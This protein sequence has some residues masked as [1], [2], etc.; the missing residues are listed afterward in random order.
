M[1]E[2]RFAGAVTRPEDGGEPTD[3]SIVP[4]PLRARRPALLE[5][6]AAILIVGGLTSLL[7]V[8]G[9]LEPATEALDLA[10]SGLAVLTLIVCLLVRAAGRGC[11]TS[12]SWP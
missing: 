5:L 3:A 4:A 2:P 10:F 7:G 1:P 8:V 11:S 12:T 6:A 9:T